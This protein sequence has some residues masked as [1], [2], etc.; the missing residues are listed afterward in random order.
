MLYSGSFL[1]IAL[2]ISI[3]IPLLFFFIKKG[4]NFQRLFLVPVLPSVMSGILINIPAEK[5]Q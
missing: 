1:N 4:G 3:Y 5:E 2:V